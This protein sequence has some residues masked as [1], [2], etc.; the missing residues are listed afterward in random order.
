MNEKILSKLIS[1]KT[2]SS[3]EAENLAALKWIKEQLVNL[4]VFINEY[5]FQ[6]F[7]SLVIT[8][9]PTKKPKIFLVS[10][11][12]VVNGSENIFVPKKSGD[13]L[14]GRGAFDMKFA[15]ASFINLFLDL[16]PEIKNFD[17]GIMITTDEEVGGKNGVRQLLEEQDFSADFCILPDGGENWTVQESAKGA[18]QI[19]VKSQGK[20]GHGSRPWTGENAIEKLQSF[21]KELSEKFTAEPCG[22]F[23]HSHDT[24]NVGSFHSGLEANLIP[25]YAEAKIDIR[26]MPGTA[27]NQIRE[28]IRQILIKYPGLSSEE[29]SA[30]E[31]YEINKANNLFLSFIQILEEELNQKTTFIQSPGS[32]DARYFL[33]KDIATILLRP[34]GG[35]HHTENEWISLSSLEQFYAVL[36]KFVLKFGKVAK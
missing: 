34:E 32:S 3:D 28:K 35:G 10:H 36:K 4:P 24:I 17:V 18:I 20:S 5:K 27:L 8:T 33:K 30:A 26:F 13:K 12:D 14:F 23:G 22:I 15:L 19:L 16:G 29:L 6:G 7:P 1:F 11:L 31:P 9:Q 2:L 25:D 21:I